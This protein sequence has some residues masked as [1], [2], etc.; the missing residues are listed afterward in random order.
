MKIMLSGIGQTVL[1]N[2]L[3][4]KKYNVD[5]LYNFLNKGSYRFASLHAQ[6]LSIALLLSERNNLKALITF[7][8]KFSVKTITYCGSEAHYKWIKFPQYFYIFCSKR[9]ARPTSIFFFLHSFI[10]V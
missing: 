3:M 10:K 9:P 7:F 4:K 1:K 2:Y 8:I 6:A 5:Y